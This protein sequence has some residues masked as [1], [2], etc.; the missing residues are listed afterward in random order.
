MALMTL[1]RSCYGYRNIV[2]SIG[3]EAPSD[4][5]QAYTHSHTFHSRVT[6]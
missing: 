2:N 1:S 3:P 6:N 5:N 4:M